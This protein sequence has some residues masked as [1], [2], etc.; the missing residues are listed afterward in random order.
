[1]DLTPSCGRVSMKIFSALWLFARPIGK[2][3]NNV[4]I[5]VVAYQSTAIPMVL[6]GTGFQKSVERLE[7]LSA[8]YIYG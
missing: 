1:M 5:L 8:E 2:I 7:G 3:W 4:C 6:S